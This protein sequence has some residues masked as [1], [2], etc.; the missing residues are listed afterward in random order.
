VRSQCPQRGF[1]LVELLAAL[2]ALALMAALAWQGVDAMVRSE[3]RT[4]GYS[5]DVLVLQTGLAQWRRDLDLVTQQPPLGGMEFDGRALRLTRLVPASPA[6]TG[7]GAV[8]ATD[9]GGLQ[10]IAWSARDIDGRRHL[11]R[12][13]SEL[14]QTRSALHQAWD[15]AAAWAQS[16]TAALRAR[17]VAVAPIDDWQI[18]YFRNNSWS[19]PLSSAGASPGGQGALPD[20]VRL[21]LTLAPGQAVGGRLTLDWVRPT[22]G[23]ASP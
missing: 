7:A 16:P 21:G 19:S 9:A 17:E 14:V 20:G 6:S 10:V 11:L 15:D 4:R 8:E 13:Q 18:F 1:T 22:L 5:E 2:A 23:A 3:Q 12:W